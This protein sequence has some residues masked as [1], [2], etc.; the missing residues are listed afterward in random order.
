MFD[1]LSRKLNRKNG[2]HLKKTLIVTFSLSE[3]Q[4]WI[5][6]KMMF[7]FNILLNNIKTMLSF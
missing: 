2:F 3:N 5:I 6:L 7:Y 1:R 4:V